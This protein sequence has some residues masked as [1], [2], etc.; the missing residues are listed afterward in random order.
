[1]KE[2]HGIDTDK[3][4]NYYTV[5]EDKLRQEIDTDIRNTMFDYVRETEGLNI[6]AI[7]SKYFSDYALSKRHYEWFA[8]TFTQMILGEQTPMTEAMRRW[9]ERNY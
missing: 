6:T 5:S 4:R 7:K 1:M 9:L 3:I 8:E 2:H